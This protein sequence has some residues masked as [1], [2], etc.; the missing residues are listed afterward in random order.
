MVEQT[1]EQRQQGGAD[2]ANAE[3][4]LPPLAQQVGEYV[5]AGFGGLVVETDE[6]E[7]ALAELYRL[8]D[9]LG[10]QLASWT[11]AGG[12]VDGQHAGD[13]AG[14]L[15]ALDAADGQVP[16]ILA[17]RGLH[18]FL[19]SPE[20]ISR[21]ERRLHEGK[22]Q[23]TCVVLLV[24]AGGVDLP[25]ELR[26]LTV[27]LRHERPGREELDTLLRLVASEP[28]ECPPD[29]SHLVDAAA[30]LTRGEAES[31]AALSLVRHGQ[32]SSGPLWQLKS[33]AVRSG[34]LMTISRAE[35]DFET[36]AAAAAHPQGFGSLRG[37]DALKDFAFRS[38]TSDAVDARGSA[39]A[40]AAWLRQESVRQGVVG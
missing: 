28:G 27:T 39:A 36:D 34:G 32:L 20:L 19:Q 22:T 21:L 8:C 6:P 10:W 13:P 12:L 30:G 40:L 38:L 4:D 11:L 15:D 23:R 5:R 35:D 37:L 14:T 2:P 18:R 25:P 24:P 29:A 16:L 7:D 1:H 26:P 3:T 33:E 17:M 31:A 9:T